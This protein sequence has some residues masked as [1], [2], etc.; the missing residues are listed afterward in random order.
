MATEAKPAASAKAA[1]KKPAAPAKKAAAAPKT[2]KAA[3][4][5]KA[6]PKAA[7]APRAKAT[8]AR[9]SKTV[10]VDPELRRHYV[11]VAAYYIAE[12]RGFLGGC[13]HEDWLAAE[14]EIDGLLQ[15]GKLS[16]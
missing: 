9:R 13:E 10:E 5:I 14:V 8:P 6:A 16:R 11:E 3:P 2:A 7:D 15:A 1:T 12:R 4:G